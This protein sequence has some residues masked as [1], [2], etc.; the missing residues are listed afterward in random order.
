[1]IDAVD[2][3]GSEEALRMEVDRIL[4][5]PADI[6]PQNVHVEI[7]QRW[8]QVETTPLREEKQ[9]P[10]APLHLAHTEDRDEGLTKQHLTTLLEKEV[11]SDVWGAGCLLKWPSGH[12]RNCRKPE[13]GLKKMH[14]FL[15]CNSNEWG[16]CR[17][18]WGA[19]RAQ[20]HVRSRSALL[21]AFMFPRLQKGLFLQE[22]YFITPSQP[23]QP[24]LLLVVSQPASDEMG[25]IDVYRPDSK[26]KFI[27]LCASAAV[28]IWVFSYVC[29][30]TNWLEL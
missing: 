28:E 21:T 13:Q 14:L 30:T 18:P 29:K 24:T 10:I 2:G 19:G 9:I 17:F 11:K 12:C 23:M 20:I 6:K 26:C 7:E 15:L 16:C 1:M 22:W 25:T 5:V 4:P 8:H 3:A 27:I